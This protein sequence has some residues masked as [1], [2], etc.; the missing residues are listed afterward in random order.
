MLR[1]EDWA[2]EALHPRICRAIGSA[3]IVAIIVLSLLPGSERPHTGLAGQIEHALAYF[4]TAVFLAF[5]FENTKTK[6][7]AVCLLTGLAAALEIIQGLIPGRHSQV[8]DW[9]ASSFGAGAGILAV[10]VMQRLFFSSE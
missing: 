9:L 6:V 8:V 1:L 7:A 5:G 10:I 4:S 3:C 2:S